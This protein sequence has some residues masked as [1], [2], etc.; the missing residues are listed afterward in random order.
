MSVK[1]S[2]EEMLAPSVVP[3]TELATSRSRRCG[4]LSLLFVGDR[5]FTNLA[6]GFEV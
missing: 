4:K 1:A 3:V 5:A 2:E 6:L